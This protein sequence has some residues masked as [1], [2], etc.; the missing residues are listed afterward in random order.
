[1]RTTLS[2][3]SLRGALALGALLVF[4]AGCDSGGDDPADDLGDNTSFAFAAPGDTVTA[5]G[6]LEEY[7]VE[8]TLDDP[9]YQEGLRV[10]AAFDEGASSLPFEALIG[11]PR[12]TTF[13]FPQSATAGASRTF[14]FSVERGVTGVGDRV[15]YT[16]QDAGGGSVGEGTFTLRFGALSV[17]EARQQPLGSGVTTEG[18]F[19]RI[20]GANARIQSPGGPTGAL[21][22]FNGLLQ[23]GDDVSVELIEEDASLPEVQSVAS[24]AALQ[25]ASGEEYESELVRVEGLSVPDSVSGPFSAGGGDG[26][27][28]YPVTDGDG[29]EAIL[30]ITDDSFYDGEPIPDESF[31][32]SGVIGQFSGS[33]DPSV[34]EGYQLLPLREGDLLYSGE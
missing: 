6:A 4:A 11:A 9:G 32:F 3:A 27:G 33:D 30:R 7:D 31:A 26:F 18:V 23:I 10:T 17:A 12:D 28:N 1:M 20:E 25:G 15:V 13:T 16:L 8:V 22:A 24:L 2:N 21:G 14:S 29:S 5:Y 19:T 34:N